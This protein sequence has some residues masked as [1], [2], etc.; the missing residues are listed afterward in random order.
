[1]KDDVHAL[2]TVAFDVLGNALD[3]FLSYLTAHTF[4]HVPPRLI[5]HL[6]DIAVRTRQIASTVDFQNKLPERDGL[7]PGRAHRRHVQVE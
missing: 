3:G 5:G 2:E 1:V 4:R 6:V 7:V